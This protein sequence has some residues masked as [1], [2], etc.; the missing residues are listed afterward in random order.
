MNFISMLVYIVISLAVGVGLIGISLN[1]S[2]IGLKTYVDNL[3]LIL[4]NNFLIRTITLLLGILIILIFIRLCQKAFARSHREKTIK[5]DTEDGKTSITITAIEDM[6]KRSLEEED[7][8][9]RIKPRILS[10]KRGIIKI[11]RASC[12]ERV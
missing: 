11:G 3:S 7:L 10:T 6:I 4:A 12:R 9:Y 2:S 5:Y 1:I 8:I